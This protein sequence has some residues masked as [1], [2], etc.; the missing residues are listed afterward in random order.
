MQ[1]LKKIIIVFYLIHIYSCFSFANAGLAR[2]LSNITNTDTVCNIWVF[3]TDK[4]SVNAS[5][6]SISKRALARRHLAGYDRLS[7][8]D[9][10]VSPQYISNIE[11]LGGKLRH[12]YKWENAA[13]FRVSS[14]V[15]EKISS[16]SFVKD[17]RPVGS[18][19]NKIRESGQGRGLPKSGSFTTDFYGGSFS[20]LDLLSVPQTHKYLQSEHPQSTPGKGVLIAFFDSGFR[21]D[22]KCF[23]YIRQNGSVVAQRDFI[24]NDSSVADPDSVV[25]NSEAPYFQ[26]DEHGSQVLSLV[27]GYDP[28]RYMGVAWGAQFAL[29]RTENTYREGYSERE[30]HSEEDNWAAAVVWAESL[31]V[32]IISSSLG[33]RDGFDDSVVIDRNGHMDTLRDY[34]YDDMDGN[35]TIVSRAAKHAVERGVLVVN[36]IGNEGSTE[37][38][39]LCAPSDV[40]GVVAVG[41]INFSGTIAYFSSTGPSSDGRIKPDV[42]APGANVYYPLIYG[43]TSNELYG[44]YGQGTSFATPL[45]AGVCALILQSHES[46]GAEQARRALLQ[47]CRFVGTQST[48]DNVYGYGLPDALLACMQRN[49]LSLEVKDEEGQLVRNALIQNAAHDSLAITDSS[50]IA[51][52]SIDTTTLPCSLSVKLTDIRQAVIRIDSLPARKTII[53]NQVSGLAVKVTDREFH[54]LSLSSVFLQTDSDTSFTPYS[55]DKNGVFIFTN[56]QTSAIR[57][58]ADAAGYSR[59]DTMT[60]H[61]C[62]ELCTLYVALYHMDISNFVLYPTLIRK[63]QKQKKILTVKFTA[64]KE[65]LQLGE[66]LIGTIYNENGQ[67]IWKNTQFADENE[68]VLF[69]WKWS[70]EKPGISPG[71]YFFVIKGRKKAFRKKFIISE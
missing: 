41:A 39:T 58:Y 18:Y 45:V 47:S 57:V 11:K 33:Y 34:T 19:I 43:A 62:T 31:G 56:Y 54:P 26:N 13:S 67:L 16:S 38:G 2:S 14:S 4:P 23:D 61:P 9:L 8:E 6:V 40:D 68:P 12:V 48:V 37:P 60:A 32:D 28:Q 21:L 1:F 59:S 5:T 30:V 7:W 24:D 42:V 3:F 35:T 52:V 46:W 29:A 36:A 55:T 22:H 15:L 63:K 64:Q 66:P 50:G 10:P 51:L 44:P 27:A 17:V 49:E 70:Q 65:E 20:Q 53:L 69:E 71:V 25:N